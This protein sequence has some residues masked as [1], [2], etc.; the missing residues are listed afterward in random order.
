MQ[1]VIFAS[2]ASGLAALGVNGSAFLIQLI[3]FILA[4]VVLR[5]F[6]FKPILK[7]LQ[8]RRD[9]I[10]LGVKLGDEMQKKDQLM[11]KKINQLLQEA[12]LKADQI[13]V[14]SE[15]TAKAIIAKAE[16]MAEKRSDIIIREAK[17]RIALEANQMKQRVENE[18]LDLISETTESILKIKLDKPTDATLLVKTFK[19]Q[20]A[21]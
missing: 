13:V 21:N 8:E 15:A 3:T 18:I 16:T 7:I 11:Q 14:D 5:K 12:R 20:Q 2:N 9:K 6:A 10:E 1:Y 19:E 17:D 4:Y